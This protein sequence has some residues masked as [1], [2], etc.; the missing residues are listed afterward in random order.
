MSLRPALTLWSTALAAGAILGFSEPPFKLVRSYIEYQNSRYLDAAAVADSLDKSSQETSPSSTSTS[1][2]FHPALHGSSSALLEHELMNLPLVQALL[3]DPALSVRRAWAGPHYQTPPG[4]APWRS[5]QV[6][7]A[8]TL[9]QPG[10]IAAKP[11]VFTNTTTRAA[12]IVLHVGHR[13]TGFPAIVH[14]GVLA[15]LLDEAL[16]RTAFLSF[17]ESAGVTANLKLKYKNPTWAGQFIVIR[18]QTDQVSERK[19]KVSGKVMTLG[20]KTLVEAEA[21]FVVPKKFKL[22]PMK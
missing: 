14:G 6:F 16:G 13:V 17:P 3:N 8:H 15:T 21:L 9:H 7:T 12:T 10:G 11:V 18:T 20:G 1:T 2:K 5:G 22:K 4:D 19:A